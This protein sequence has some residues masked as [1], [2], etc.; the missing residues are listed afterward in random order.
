METKSVTDRLAA[1]EAVHP[2]DMTDAELL[3]L[4]PQFSAVVR[5]ATKQADKVAPVEVKR[6]A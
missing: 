1:G 2:N 3:A 5:R 4:L 6:A